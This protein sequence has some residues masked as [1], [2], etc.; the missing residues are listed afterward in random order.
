MT[1]DNIHKAHYQSRLPTKD[2]TGIR[3]SQGYKIFFAQS[4]QAKKEELPKS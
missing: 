4:F 2:K 1:Q 3:K